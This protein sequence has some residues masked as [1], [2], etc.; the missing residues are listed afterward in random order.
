MIYEIIKVRDM[1]GAM[2]GSRLRISLVGLE[3]LRVGYFRQV[4][5]YDLV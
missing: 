5:S 3:G 2:G 4:Y 1:F